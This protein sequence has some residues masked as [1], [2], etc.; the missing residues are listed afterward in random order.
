[1]TFTTSLE[2]YAKYIA[3]VFK[4]AEFGN[5]LEIVLKGGE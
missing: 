1:M 5:S 3:V 2:Y 4:E